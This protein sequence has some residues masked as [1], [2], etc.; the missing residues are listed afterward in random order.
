MK[1]SN[2]QK[3][4]YMVAMVWMLVWA[5]V[6]TEMM[7]DGAEACMLGMVQRRGCC[8]GG[9]NPGHMV[10]LAEIDSVL[11]MPGSCAIPPFCQTQSPMPFMDVF[12]SNADT[13]CAPHID[14]FNTSG[15]AY[16]ICKNVDD[17]GT[18]VCY[19]RASDGRHNIDFSATAT[20]PCA[21]M[22][23]EE[24]GPLMLS[25]LVNAC[26]VNVRLYEIAANETPRITS[27]RPLT[28]RPILQPALAPFRG[29]GSTR[30]LL[31]RDT[32]WLG[33]VTDSTLFV[34]AMMPACAPQ[35]ETEKRLAYLES[36]N[37]NLCW[38]WLVIGGCVGAI[39]AYVQNTRDR[40]AAIE[41]AQQRH[42]MYNAEF[43]LST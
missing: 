19:G 2:A 6:R 42:D 13:M 29:Q 26:R 5:T 20:T 33:D 23:E 35:Q 34:D 27:T 10:P 16:V 38:V 37:N 31:K 21:R 25:G 11:L 15:V 36:Y 32:A 40:V 7:D 8:M 24:G 22:R 4:G 43:T 28:F 12:H 1:I 41:E 17:A 30:L 14:A 18:F 9:W 39:F 3:A